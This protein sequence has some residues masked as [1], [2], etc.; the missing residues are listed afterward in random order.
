M[1]SPDLRKSPS[2]L[3]SKGKFF[4]SLSFLIIKFHLYLA[5]LQTKIPL[6]G[7][8]FE[9]GLNQKW[10]LDMK[11][12]SLVEQPKHCF[13]DDE[14]CI[15]LY[16]NK[17]DYIY[18]VRNYAAQTEFVIISPA[19]LVKLPE[20]KRTNTGVYLPIYFKALKIFQAEITQHVLCKGQL[21][22][23]HHLFNCT[24]SAFFEKL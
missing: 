23:F 7:F 8:Y 15:S 24:V 11:Y 12:L 18:Y 6:F 5:N 21:A 1:H 22:H 2:Q 4:Q 13:S 20:Q 16:E 19:L 3:L 14:D 17:G 9:A 10:K